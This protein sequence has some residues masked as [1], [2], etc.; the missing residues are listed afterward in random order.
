[1]YQRAFHEEHTIFL[2]V[3]TKLQIL[4][5]LYNGWDLGIINKC[6][7]Q[8]IH[9]KY[10]SVNSQNSYC[11]CLRF[12]ASAT[13]SAAFFSAAKSCWTPWLW[14]AMTSSVTSSMPIAVTMADPNSGANKLFAHHTFM[15]RRFCI[16]TA[17]IKNFK[18][19]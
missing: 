2:L 3:K 14:L 10:P 15:T 7:R 5:L 8:M 17:L 12:L 1:M 6:S 18:A 4:R 13:F 11:S 9:L 19:F 16:K